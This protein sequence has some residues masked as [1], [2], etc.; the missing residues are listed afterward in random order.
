MKHIK[1]L[2]WFGSIILFLIGCSNSKSS[3]IDNWEIPETDFPLGEPGPHFID[4]KNIKLLMKA[5]MGAR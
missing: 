4:T 5:E 2:L 3:K 1:Y